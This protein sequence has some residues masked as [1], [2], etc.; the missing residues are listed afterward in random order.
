MVGPGGA[1]LVLDLGAQWVGPG[2]TEMLR[3]IRE[4]GLHVVPTA[5]P[6]RAIWG[7]GGHLEQGGAALPPVPPT[8][9]AEVLASGALV[10]LMSR[11]VP[12][13]GPVASLAGPAVGPPHGG[14]LDTPASA[15]RGRTGLRA[16]VHQGRRGDRAGRDVRARPALRPPVDRAGPPLGHGRGLPAARG[17]ARA[18]PAARRTGSAD[19]IRLRRPGAGHHPGLRTASPSTSDGGALRC[20]RVAVCV[21]PPLASRIAFTPALPDGRARLLASL[22]MGASV[23]FHAVYQRPFWR[24]R[25]LS[26]Q[27][28]TATGHRQP[29]LRQLAARRDRARRARRPGGGGRGPPPGRAGSRRAGAGDPGLA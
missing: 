24:A 21:P 14:G 6:G 2:Q 23:K 3:H 19:R 20:R 29:D 25:G 28:W 15:H 8:V 9:L 12:P 11:S 7:L 5:V 1:P 18:G 26:G 17:D 16:D 27:A 13:R 4:L 22:P 10:A